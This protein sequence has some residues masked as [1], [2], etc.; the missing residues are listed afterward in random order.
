MAKTALLKHIYAFAISCCLLPLCAQGDELSSLAKHPTWHRLLHYSP[1]LMQP[2]EVKSSLHSPEFFLAQ[3]G[4]RNPAS[5]LA[6]TLAA[7]QAPVTTNP[8]EHAKCRFPAR[9]IWLEKQ[10][11]ALSKQLAAIPCPEFNEW[12]PITEQ[13]SLS[14]MFA[15]GYLGNPA[16]YYGHIFLKINNQQNGQRLIDQTVNYGAIESTQ[17]DPLSYIV[18]GISGGYDGGFSPIDFFFHDANY[19][20]NELRDL[21]EY[22]IKLPPAE[23]RFIISHTWE[24]MRKRYV[25]YFFHDNCA[26]RVGELLEVVDGIHAN[27]S[28]TPWIIPQSLLQKLTQ[29]TFQGEPLLDK[30]IFHPSRQTRLYHRY[31]QL[32]SQQRELVSGLVNQEI[33]LDDPALTSLSVSER[34]A[35]IDTLLDYH[36]F[37]KEG[38]KENKGQKSSPA[39]LAAL[40]ARFQLPPGE[41]TPPPTLSEPPDTGKAPSW[42]QL[43][44]T[45]HKN[46]GDALSLRLR[47]AYYDPLDVSNG[48]AR[49]GGLSMGD[50]QLE[51]RESHLRLHHLDIISIDSMNPA[52]TGLPGDQ[53]AGWRLRAGLEQE[54]QNCKSCLATRIQSD[55][56]RGSQLGGSALFASLHLGGAIQAHTNI[57]GYGFARLGASL[58]FRPSESFGIHVSHEIRQPIARARASYSFSSAEIR[59][60]LGKSHDLRARVERDQSSTLSLGLGSYW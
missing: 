22:R 60:V 12:A 41:P 30:R 19:G 27:P 13:S 4:A 3:D 16:S 34:Y 24:V 44:I 28:D 59:F 48:Q 42:T 9:R 10:L 51:V 40:A 46:R 53:G 33:R 1:A 47:P 25:Y 54:R 20:E 35:V 17:D 21:W 8:D 11:P 15:N 2:D 43:G 5:E 23:V 14:L 36:Q 6:A 32:N 49:H 58:V 31:R 37:R 38:S 26:F 18:K 39:Y 55:Y 45:H 56:T 7:M 52:V 57:D 50:L 29:S